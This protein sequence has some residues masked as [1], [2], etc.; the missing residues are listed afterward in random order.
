MKRKTLKYLSLVTCSGIAGSIVL[1]LSGCKA[2]GTDK[3]AALQITSKPEASV[4]LDGKHIGKT[5]FYADQLKSGE[6][7]LKLTAS[8]ADFVEKIDL[9]SQTLT[10]INRELS[11]N[12]MAQAGENLYLK[13]GSG[14]FVSSMPNQ[15]DLTVDDRLVGQTPIL[16]EKIDEGEHK[17]HL[18]KTGYQDRQF[19]V[20][21]SNQYQLV[22][23]ATLASEIA[24]GII[25]QSTSPAPQVQV[26]K[27]E[28]TQTPQGFLRV[29]QDPTTTAAEIGRVN[30]GDQLEVIQ[31]TADWIQVRFQGKQGWISTQ[32]TKGL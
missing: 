18:T 30:T 31:K 4:F 13:E 32:Y 9:A 29:R 15:A 8:Q 22:V 27:V 23:Q 12:F 5:P 2:I 24:K 10:V 14:L 17:L 25:S 21:I 20:K 3:P 7:T 26:E 28:I 19:A 6:H 16:I 11:N 1:I